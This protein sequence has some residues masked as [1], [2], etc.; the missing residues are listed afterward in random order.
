MSLPEGKAP[1]SVYTTAFAGSS[2][3]RGLARIIRSSLALTIGTR[4]GPYEVISAIGAGGMGEVYRAH[5]TVLGRDVAI[6][7]LP[8]SV[9]HDA[10]R[11]ARFEREAKLLAALNHPHIAGIHGVERVADARFLVLE[12]VD[13]VSLAKRIQSGPLVVPEALGIARQIA[14]ALEAAHEK[15]IVHRD[16]KPANVMMTTD[17]RVKVLDFG[18]AKALETEAVMPSPDQ[19]PT[20]TL[21]AVTQLGVVLGTAAYMSPEQAKGRPTDKRSDLWAF[22]CV[23]YEMLTGRRAFEGEDV[24]ETLAAV[25]RGEPDWTRLPKETPASIQRLVRRCLAKDRKLRLPDAAMARIELDEA[26]EWIRV[27]RH[28]RGRT[29]VGVDVTRPSGRARRRRC[30]LPVSDDGCRHLD[31]YAA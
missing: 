21:G 27:G 14:D 17:D 24:S 16:L 12:L 4:L 5:D 20:M 6:K 7:A 15:G 8:D 28:D 25:I 2:R 19:S 18:L 23:L 29:I 26:I 10:E 3:T 31:I 1:A 22:G 13:G 11:V 30:R 9:A